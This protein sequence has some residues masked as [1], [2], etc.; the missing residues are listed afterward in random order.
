M[1]PVTSQRRSPIS[2]WIRENLGLVAIVGLLAALPF[3]IALLD[4]QSIPSLLANEA[5]QSKFIQGLMIEVFILAIFALSYDLIFG[6]TGL[7]SFGHAMFFAVGAYLT[8]IMLKSFGWSLLPTFGLMIVAAIL[9]ALLF[10][11]VLPRVRGVTFALVTLG[12]AEV[13]H[14]VIQSR[15]AAKYT[16]ADVGLQGAIPPAFLSPSAERL[17]FY[18]LAMAIT[19]LVYLLCRRFVDS[20]TGRVCIATRDNEDRA[21]M[22]GYNTFYFKLAA[23][24]VSSLIAGLAGM[25]HALYQPLVSPNIASINY[26]VNAL[27]MVLVGGIGT[28]SGAPI[29][30]AV[31]RLM[32]FYFDKWFAESSG[33]LLGIVYVLLVLFVPY[34]IVGTWRLRS[35]QWRQGWQRRLRM[36]GTRSAENEPESLGE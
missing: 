29:G 8:G 21:L 7:L 31:L 19:V 13:F 2:S 6:I 35:L 20:P 3:V 14:I 32:T 24:I 18:F 17:R 4:D 27:L 34:G 9:Q 10:S 15:E 28:L 30:A 26:T 25:M 36:L 23:L 5:G 22:L 33:F 12:M 16:G 11:L 1:N